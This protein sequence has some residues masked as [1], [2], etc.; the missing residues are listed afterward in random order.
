MQS[1]S[2]EEL[3]PIKAASCLHDCVTVVYYR[4]GTT[5]S[6]IKKY[7]VFTVYIAV[8]YTLLAVIN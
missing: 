6:E 2:A 5:G 4:S 7:R 8:S 3:T 1:T